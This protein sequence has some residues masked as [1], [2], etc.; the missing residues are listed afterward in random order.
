MDLSVGEVT[1]LVVGLAVVLILLLLMVGVLYG[2][3]RKAELSVGRIKSDVEALHA[4]Q[5]STQL[6]T[7]SLQSMDAPTWD[8]FY[9]EAFRNRI[10][11]NPNAVGA[12]FRKIVESAAKDADVMV[13]V[14]EERRS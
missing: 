2:K 14:K 13:R 9:G 5:E 8:F 4:L 6:T 3:V 7:V 12:Q 10:A 11:K 1:G